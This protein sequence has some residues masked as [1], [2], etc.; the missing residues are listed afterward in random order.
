MVLLIWLSLLY[1][2]SR[3]LIFRKLDPNEVT[4]IKG[5]TPLVIVSLELIFLIRRLQVRKNLCMKDSIERGTS[6]VTSKESNCKGPLELAPKRTF[7]GEKPGS[8]N[9]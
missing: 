8:W 1:L 5:E 6:S 9:N 2:S 7:K 3:I 4:N